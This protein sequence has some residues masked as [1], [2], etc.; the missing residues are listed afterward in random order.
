MLILQYIL[1]NEYLIYNYMYQVNEIIRVF[2][3][4]LIQL[5][6]N[7]LF[8]ALNKY[9]YVKHKYMDWY[10]IKKALISRTCSS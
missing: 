8:K 1:C 7:S 2:K 6:V 5:H 4:V 10:F 9:K 3:I